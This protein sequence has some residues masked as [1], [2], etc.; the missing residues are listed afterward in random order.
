MLIL[1]F[2]DINSLWY[3]YPIYLYD[4]WITDSYDNKVQKV[5]DIQIT[6]MSV[7]WHLVFRVLQDLKS[8]P[9]S[10][11]NPESKGIRQRTI[12]KCTSPMMIYKIN[13]S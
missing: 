1:K 10:C 9:G 5:Q 13:P 12:N 6:A 2:I 11:R 3:S 7:V 8:L 4:F